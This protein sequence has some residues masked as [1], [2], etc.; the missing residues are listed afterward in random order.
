MTHSVQRPSRLIGHLLKVRLYN[1]RLDC[2]LSGSL[3]LTLARGARAHSA[4]HG[5]STTD[6]SSPPSKS[7]PQR[8]RV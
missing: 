5:N 3:V 6:T 8:F 2:Y 7:K 1:D 4:G